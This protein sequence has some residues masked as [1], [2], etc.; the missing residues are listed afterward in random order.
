MPPRQSLFSH[1]RLSSV[2]MGLGAAAAGTACAAIR[3]NTEYLPATLCALFAMFMQLAGNFSYRRADLI[4]MPKEIKSE[5]S[6]FSFS[7]KL[8]YLRECSY[9]CLMLAGICGMAL[10][11]MGGWW[12]MVVGA[13]IIGISR[14]T[15]DGAIPLLRTPYGILAP[16]ILF[17]P[18]CVICT[19]LIQSMHE[20]THPLN[21][22]DIT[23][24]LYMSI[25]IGLMCVNAT[26]LYSYANYPRDRK[27]GKETFVVRIGRRNA[28]IIFIINSVIYTV[29]TVFMCLKLHLSLNGL[30]MMPS[31]LCF[32]LDIY[33]WWKMR[34]L[35]RTQLK[36]LV[37]VGNF[38]V[39]LMGL[40]SFL[41][42][43]LTG[44]PDDSTLTFF[45][46]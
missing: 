31:T 26:M 23:P 1:I 15:M 20:A 37:D 17:G 13:F 19:S 12:V 45:G 43:E 4:L 2:M 25:V 46:I 38:N 8:L 29:V 41:I 21:W 34:T 39:L 33:I 44:V 6:Q 10:A 7:D 35:K 28:R 30:D 22:Y 5:P 16:F 18:V 24:S 40:L 36:E 9:T 11:A 27:I 42:F 32:I 3:G 14:F